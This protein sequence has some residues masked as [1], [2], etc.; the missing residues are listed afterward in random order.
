MVVGWGGT[1]GHLR[2]AV[3]KLNTSGHKVS[4]AHFRFISPL[5]SNTEMILKKFKKVVVAEQN[6]GQFAGY[7]MDK[8]PGLQV[9]KYNKVEGQPFAVSDLIEAF[10]KQLGE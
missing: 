1:Y 3:E 10:T 8:I 2:E 6:N 4:M 9:T 7:L 5:P